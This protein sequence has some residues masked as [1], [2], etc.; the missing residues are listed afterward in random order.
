VKLALVGFVVRE[1]TVQE[2]CYFDRFAKR[3]LARF[4]AILVQ[5]GGSDIQL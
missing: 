4:T 3:E 2:I 1:K 5:D